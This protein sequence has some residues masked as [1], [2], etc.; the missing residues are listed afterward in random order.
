MVMG[1]NQNLIHQFRSFCIKSAT[2]YEPKF[3]V[4]VESD[5]RVNKWESKR[6]VAVKYN[7]R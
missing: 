1:R 3:N 7:D 5:K 6:H 4:I 2:W